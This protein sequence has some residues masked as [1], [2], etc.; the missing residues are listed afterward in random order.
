[1]ANF[2]FLGTVKSAL[3]SSIYHFFNENCRVFWLGKVI[4]VFQVLFLLFFSQF[5]IL[6][7][8]FETI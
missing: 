4:F 5:D 2:Y 3:A 7:G 1:M 8:D 6:L